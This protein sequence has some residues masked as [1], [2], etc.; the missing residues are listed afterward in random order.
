MPKA[1][2]SK[3]KAEG[4]K[5]NASMARTLAEQRWGH[6]GTTS[7]KVN[8][9][10]AFYFSCSSHGGYVVDAA[11]LTAEERA[12]VEKYRKPEMVQILVQDGEVLAVVGPDRMTAKRVWTNPAKGPSDWLDHPV[13]YF[14]EDCDWSILES[15][16]GIIN[17]WA[18]GLKA[19]D[20]AEYDRQR[21]AACR[22]H[23]EPNFWEKQ[24]A[25]A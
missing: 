19:E 23:L 16:T 15:Y 3:G 8:R 9:P 12:E 4:F 2:T 1:A 17:Q 13:F 10:G 25:A 14:E 11:A 7:C 22:Y 20:E 6:G 24:A 21:N 18:A 5:I